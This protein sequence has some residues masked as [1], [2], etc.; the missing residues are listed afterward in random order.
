[1]DVRHSLPG[2]A[3]DLHIDKSVVAMLQSK[4]Q[5]SFKSKEAV[6]QLFAADLTNSTIVVSAATQL[7]PRRSSRAS[8]TFDSDEALQQRHDR[9]AKGLYCIGLWH[10]HPELAPEPS[11]TD[12]RLAADHAQAAA[13][14]LHALAFIIVGTRSFPDGWYVG[15]HDGNVFHRAIPQG[16]DMHGIVDLNST[17]IDY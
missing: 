11:M 2:A 1:M 16:Q 15:F 10:T 6:G 9:L 5:R 12:G 4:S 7:T 8:V 13:S 17:Q 14:I 3:W